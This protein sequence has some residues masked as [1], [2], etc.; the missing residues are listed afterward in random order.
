MLKKIFHTSLLFCFN[1]VPVSHSC[2]I[3]SFI[4]KSKLL[5]LIAISRVLQS[6]AV[7]AEAQVDV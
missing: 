2:I 5:C 1:K 6:F 3:S 4:F 7:P